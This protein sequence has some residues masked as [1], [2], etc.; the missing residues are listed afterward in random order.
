MM[1]ALLFIVASLGLVAAA[2]EYRSELVL[3]DE[4]IIG[5][6]VVSTQP[7]FVKGV[8]SLPAELDYR[9]LGLM[10][11]DLNQHVPVYCGSC[12]AHSALSSIADRIKIMTKGTYRDVIPSV[13]ALL[14]CGSAGTCQVRI[15]HPFSLRALSLSLSSPHLSHYFL[16][17]VP[18]P[19]KKRVVIPMPQTRGFTKMVAYRTSLASPTW[20]RISSAPT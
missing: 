17:T 13:Q 15:P 10:T 20:H 2:K 7:H 14:N 12:W 11:G 19:E 9:K 16:H 5:S 18:S 1:R 6:H 8:T 3:Q 4:T